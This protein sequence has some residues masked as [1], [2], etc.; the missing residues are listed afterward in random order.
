MKRW[1]HDRTVGWL[2]CLF[3]D[4][5]YSAVNHGTI[6]LDIE[7]EDNHKSRIESKKRILCQHDSLHDWRC[8]NG[9][10]REPLIDIVMVQCRVGGPT[11]IRWTD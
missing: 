8:R 11:R 9:F 2:H 10:M 6:D 5:K 1:L 3:D 7:S 4:C